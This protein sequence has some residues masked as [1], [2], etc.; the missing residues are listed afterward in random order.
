MLISK[1]MDDQDKA[2]DLTLKTLIFKRIT[3]DYQCFLA[4]DFNTKLILHLV[5]QQ[6]Y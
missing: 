4:R 2:K 1:D 5:L 6:S 3:V